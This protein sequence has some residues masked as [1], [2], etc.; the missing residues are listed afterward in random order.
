MYAFLVVIIGALII[1]GLIVKFRSFMAG[2]KG[3]PFFQHVNDVRTELGKN[4]VYSTSSSWISKFA[5]PLDL[6][7]SFV[8][9][10]CIP[11]GMHGSLVAFQGDI[12][13][14]LYMLSLGKIMIM[15]VAMDSASA[16]GGIGASREVFFNMICEPAFMILMAT[17]CMVTGTWSFSQLF[18]TFGGD[19]FNLLVLSVLVGYGI[20]RLSL[21]ETSR[22]PVDDPR[23][24]LELTMIHEA[25][26]LDL[27]GPDVAFVKISS[28]IKSSIWCVLCVNTFIPYNLPFFIELPLLIAGIVVYA[29]LVAFVESFRARSPLKRIP[30]YILSIS[31]IGLL[32]FIAGYAIINIVN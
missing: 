6:A 23:T 18:A 31:A 32:A 11:L 9:M 12:I 2:R 7:S 24:H 21:V 19:T 27:S 20:F 28:W 16:F 22:V 15:L 17:L 4:C 25:Q 13:F 29:L 30:I 14:M 26:I 8:A 5:A 1:P 3:R 10:L